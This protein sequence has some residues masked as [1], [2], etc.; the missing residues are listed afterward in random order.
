[1]PN[2]P[3]FEGCRE[4]RIC[5]SLELNEKIIAYQNMVR[6]R[7]KKMNYRKSEAAS[8]LFESLSVHVDPLIRES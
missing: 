4:I 3:Q 6:Y 8:D 1:M 2:K 5:V 7:K